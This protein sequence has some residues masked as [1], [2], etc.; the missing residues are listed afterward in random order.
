[1]KRRSKI[2]IRIDILTI[3]S[4][5]GPSRITHIMYDSNTNCAV[6]KGNLTYMIKQGLVEKKYVGQERIAYCITPKGT[7]ILSAFKEL[8]QVLPIV[9]E[10]SHQVSTII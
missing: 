8:R 7:S 9:E 5:R 10:T 6:L 3:L 2:E 1:M 4:Q